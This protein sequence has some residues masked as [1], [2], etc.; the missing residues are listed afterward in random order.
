MSVFKQHKLQCLFIDNK[1]DPLYIL[2][3]NSEL[4]K[5]LSAKDHQL[6]NSSIN[7][8]D[9]GETTYVSNQNILT[10]FVLAPQA[11]QPGCSACVETFDTRISAIPVY[12]FNPNINQGVISFALET[13]V[14]NG[15]RVVPGIFW[16]QV[17]LACFN[18][19]PSIYQS[20]YFAFV[21]SQAASFGA[22]M[23]YGGTSLLMVFDSMS[24]TLNPSVMFTTVTPPFGF[25]N[26]GFLREGSAPTNNTSWGNYSA[27]AFD[28]S[29]VWFSGQY[30]GS[31]NNWS[32]Y[33][34][35]L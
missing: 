24:T 18:C 16:G 1:E 7:V 34:G 25:A 28:G 22:L 21:G 33:I 3:P 13:G 35:E 5:L 32:T 27:T 19:Y 6:Q 23:P 2:L 4:G 9:I 8:V 10:G 14:N 26:P 29:R 20:G 17:S 15:T 11:D 12:T 31:N 30:S